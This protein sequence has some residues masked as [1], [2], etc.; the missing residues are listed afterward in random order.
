MERTL[1]PYQQRRREEEAIN[2]VAR[3]V[4]YTAVVLL[5]LVAVR[6]AGL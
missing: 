6:A 1:S 5:V 2:G 4:A 3:I